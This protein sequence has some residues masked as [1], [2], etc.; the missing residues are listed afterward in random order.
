MRIVSAAFLTI[1]VLAG[2]LHA[3]NAKLNTSLKFLRHARATGLAKAD[4]RRPALAAARADKITVT[5]KFDH[6]LS[7]AEIA[8]F[9]RQGADF[10]RVD[11]A[12]AHTGPVYAISIP[13]DAVDAVAARG[14]V[15]KIDAAWRPAIF[16]VLDVSAHEI[17]ADSAW[18]QLDPL[19]L[20]LTGKGMRISDF[21]TG[22]D[23]F[24]PSFFRADG[25]TFSW[26]DYDEDWVFTPG[27][28]Y[29][30]LNRNGIADPNEALA[31]FDGY[32]YDPALVWGTGYPSNAGNG[33]QTYWDWLYN[34]ANRNY[35]RDY[36]PAAGYTES[37]PSFGELVFT[38][39]DADDDGVLDPG[40]K[41]VALKTSKIYATMTGGAVERLRGVDLIQS[42]ADVNGHGTAVSGILAGGTVGRHIFTG[43]APD[44]EILMG[45]FFSGNPISALIPWA[46]S[47]GSDV[48]LYEFGGF[49]WDYLDGSSLEEELITVMNDTVIQVTPSGNLGR[50][51]KHAI[52]AAAAADSAVLQITVPLASGTSIMNL[53]STTLWRTSL[54][55]LT[56]RLKS[57]KGG[58]IT[59]TGGDAYINGYYVW[60]DA[61]TSPR[62][63]CAMNVYVDYNTNPSLTGTWELHVVNK[64]GA[65]VEVISNVADDV[66]S[67]AG[68]AE[69]LNYYS[70][71]RNVTWP[72]TADGAFVNGSY[73]TRGFEGYGG[74][75]GG[76]I[77]VGQISAFSG[78]GTRVDGRHLLD[79]VSPGNYDV[80]SSMSSQN[81]S[82]YGLGGYRQ[83]SGTSA[84]GPHVAAACALVQ[85]KFPFATMKDVALLITANAATDA[86]TGSVY[87]DTWGWGKLRILH[88]VGVPTGVDDIARGAAPPRVLLDQN[89]PNPFNPTTWIPF[90]LPSD[91]LVSVKI[92]N[93]GGRL[94]TV[95]RERQMPMGAHSVRW[96]GDD[97]EGRN[98]SSGIYFCVLKFGNETQTRK[99]V[100]LR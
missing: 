92:Y 20:P 50:G 49:V 26:I 4:D 22:I 81:G 19:G 85:Q 84:A 40:E 66:T 39:I 47:R 58:M 86:F 8:S 2:S 80:Y 95:L 15:L 23:V 90:Y 43:I 27:Y 1:S 9:E 16:P 89:Y 42:E 55:G 14:D 99:L 56:F 7:D 82:G 38:A 75:G 67:W 28:D 60:S 96:N 98:V 12:V 54:S 21:D 29:V 59:L 25:D 65:P 68:G 44:A 94:V 6:I 71:D 31:Y 45:Y 87:N 74:V 48:M 30:D 70:N 57:P 83:F 63:T 61:S 11:G 100:L 62:G 53:W 36:G 35:K 76:S 33:Y 52:A 64:S 10:F 97:R 73:S 3:E 79:I 78:R 5:A 41:I 46:R 18:R 93:V 88:A 13:W 34:D 51:R 17:E 72:A 69:F 24:H 77:P 32:I 37:T 91:G